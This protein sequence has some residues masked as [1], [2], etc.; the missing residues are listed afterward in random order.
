MARIGN[1]VNSGVPF[2]KG[3]VQEVRELHLIDAN[4]KVVPASIESRSRWLGDGSLK[5]VT[6][7]F[8]ADMDANSTRQYRLT[9]AP[10]HV[11]QSDLDVREESGALTVVTG[12]AKFVIPTDHLGPFRQ[13]YLRSDPSKS[14]V[15]SDG[16]LA[17]PATIVLLARNGE[18]R[19]VPR[20]G[21]KEEYRSEL[22]RIGDPFTQS[23]SV[24]SVKVEERGPGRVV[25]ALKGTFSTLQEKSLD[26]TARLY[27]YNGSPLVQMTFSVVNRQMDSMARFVGI[28]RLVVELPLKRADTARVV[29]SRDGQAF[30]AKAGPKP[31][32]LVQAALDTMHITT[33]DGRIY[34]GTRSEGWVRVNTAAAS[35]TA[36]TRWFWQVYPMGLE[37]APDGTVGLELKPAGTD[38]VDLY[39]A[40]AKTHFLFFHFTQPGATPPASLAAGTTHPL[41]AA[42][43]PDRYCQDT[44]ALGDL[45]SANPELYDPK[46]RDL[47][48]RYQA[49]VDAC[50]NRLVSNRPRPG[51]K[52]DE[53]G[54]LN[55]GSGLHHR[56]YVRENA[57]ESWWDSN[58]YDFPHAA[59]INYLRTGNLINL[60]TAEEAGLHLADLDICHSFPGY[61]DRAGS[62]RSGPVVGHFRNY[63]SA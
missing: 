50:L 46:Y 9:T 47:A 55:F 32:R 8:V 60:T 43:S 16:A 7:H 54:W 4:G 17:R 48:S 49:Q 18:S 19:V 31:L 29:L 13:V 28:E 21:S 2:P 20:A 44:R 12:P 30:E 61:P 45:F 24:R 23:A 5:W 25:I 15:E 41:V 1:P 59:L 10:A 3:A 14:F 36:G 58:Y 56:N 57:S 62:P 6:V 34:D 37:V 53:Y 52:V 40:G 63:A 35:L 22:V 39:T 42:C 26:F 11:P 27:F 51:W 38:R 33:G